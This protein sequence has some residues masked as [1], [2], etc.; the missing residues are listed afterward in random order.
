MV[1]FGDSLTLRQEERTTSG[2]VLNWQ[3]KNGNWHSY[4]TG[5]VF[6]LHHN[7]ESMQVLTL[8]NIKALFTRL[9]GDTIPHFRTKHEMLAHHVIIHDIFDY[10][11]AIFRVE[12]VEVYVVVSNDLQTY[13][14]SDGVY[15]AS[16]FD[17]V[18]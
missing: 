13:I 3:L 11:D 18:V 5:K 1:I 10:R 8:P 14:A 4:A 16:R 12:K 6:F 15:E 9:V 7:L 2:A 17:Q